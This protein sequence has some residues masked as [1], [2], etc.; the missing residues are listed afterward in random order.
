MA[1]KKSEKKTPV[2]SAPASAQKTL[3]DVPEILEK[4]APSAKEAK[5]AKEDAK[6][7]PAASQKTLSEVPEMKEM[8]A[9][10]AAKKEPVHADRIFQ[11]F[12]EHSVAEFFK[13]NRQMLGFSGKTRSLTTIVHEYVCNSLDACEEAGILPDI[14]IEIREL[15]EEHYSVKSIDNGPGIPK[16]HIG[17]ALGMMLAGT[18]FNRYC[19]QRGQQGIGATG[20]T[21]FAQLTTGKPI[22]FKTGTGKGQIYTG[23]LSIDVRSNNPLITND[24]EFSGEF[25]G[26]EVEAEFAEVKYDKSSY[27]VS[28][29][30]KRTALANPHAQITFIAPDAE[31]VTFQ[32]SVMEVPKKPQEVLP[33]PLGI[34]TGDLVEFAHHSDQRKIT[35]FLQAAF[36]RVSPAKIDELRLLVG[37]D[38]DKNPQEMTWPEAEELVKAFQKVK[39]ISPATDSIIPIGKAQIEASLKNILEPEFFA[40]TERKPKLYRGGIPFVVEAAI[41]Y[42]GGSG[43]RIGDGVQGDI[44]RYANR[45]PLLFDAGGCGI[46]EAVKSIEWRRYDMK[47]FD[48]MPVTIFVNFVSVYVPY[49]G[50]GKQ[51]ISNEE[52]VVIEIKNAVME[53]AR[54][55]QR[56]IHGVFRNKDKATR[57]QAIMRYVTQLAKDLPELAEEGKS[58]QLEE[59]LIKL[60]EEKY[61]VD[62]ALDEEENGT[63]DD[64][65]NEKDD[66]EGKEEKEEE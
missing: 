19:Q 64:K 24:I 2:K 14:T 47:N 26:L 54:L 27:G 22:H 15:S 51:A 12:Q 34:Q 36:T 65:G 52:D 43:K 3:A 33:H 6:S 60:I 37:V 35:S 49:T 50:A 4:N 59:K 66:D 18:K 58:K 55:A 16:K 62:D 25:R 28:E 7:I 11:K 13:K 45:A 17:K 20:V 30:L 57:R 61:Q 63:S 39:W 56:Y 44:V 46:T 9:A 40:V 42:G 38:L 8:S 23:E 32:R 1:D 5:A 29:Y 21:M 31:S 48:E 41:A 10:A 53:V